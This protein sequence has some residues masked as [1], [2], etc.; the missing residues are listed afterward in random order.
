MNDLYIAEDGTV[1]AR[2]SSHTAGTST[3]ATYHSQNY[4][5]SSCE[6]STGRKLCFWL[7]SLAAALCV[8][9]FLVTLCDFIDLGNGDF[10]EFFEWILPY[11]IMGGSL[12]GM[13]L[14]GCDGADDL[15]YN[16]GAFILSP[17][18]AA[19]GAIGIGFVICVIPYVLIGVGYLLAII[20]GLSLLVAI[21]SGGD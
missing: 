1:H 20:L 13:L 5:S 2:D 12:L 8:G 4:D 15:S 21:I 6:V 10:L 9:V 17:L 14:Y 7:C 19:L 16:L 11:G 3:S 18:C